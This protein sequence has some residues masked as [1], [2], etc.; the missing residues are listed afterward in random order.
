MLIEYDNI[1]C[2]NEN[3]DGSVGPDGLNGNHNYG[4]IFI[5]DGSG[6]TRVELQEGNHN[7]NNDWDSTLAQNPINKRITTGTTFTSLK[8]ILTYSFSNYKIVPRKDDDFAGYTPTAVNETKPSLPAAY[9]L[10]QNYPNPFNPSTVISYSIPKSSLV[11]IKIFNILGQE[12]K[13]LISQQQNPGTY[14]VS[15]DASKLSSGVYFYSLTAGG[16]NQ[17]KKMMLLK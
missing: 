11:T 7:Y 5:S 6:D 14:K 4:E 8:G 12:V 17:V 13:T 16:F 3:A 2:T 1:S 15:F 10:N 9:T